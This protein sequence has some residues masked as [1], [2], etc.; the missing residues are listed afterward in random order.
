MIH[1]FGHP[2]PPVPRLIAALAARGHAVSAAPSGPQAPATAGPPG[3]GPAGAGPAHAT[4]VLGPGEAMDPMALGVLLGGWRKAEGSRLLILSLLGAHPDAGAPRLRRMWELEE[5]ARE[6]ALPV[7]TLRLAPLLGPES[8]LWLKLRSRPRLPR[9]GRALLNP[10]AEHDVIETLE[11]SL[12][13]R[14]RWRGWYEVAGPEPVSLSELA[15]FARGAGPALR[16]GSGAW[17]PPLA[18]LDEHRLC[19]AGP[20]I[21]HFGITPRPIAERVAEWAA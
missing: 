10:V 20:W 1:V 2:D 18:E 17:E 12:D 11:R 15:E 21:E 19:E 8:P 5:R 7:L 14:A 3:S 13:G 6:F 9:G 4:L 16:F